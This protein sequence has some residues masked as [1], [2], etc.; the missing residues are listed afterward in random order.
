MNSC[1]QWSCHVYRPGF[2]STPSG[3]LVLIFFPP[4]LVSV[5]WHWCREMNNHMIQLYQFGA[6]TPN[7]IIQGQHCSLHIHVDSLRK[8]IAWM[9]ISCWIENKHGVHV[10]NG[11][12]FNHRDGLNH[13][14]FKVYEWIWKIHTK[15]GHPGLKTQ[16]PL[17][18]LICPYDVQILLMFNT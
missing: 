9:S 15:G 16:M 7:Y 6:Y 1:V 2:H 12:L 13:N 11:I 14:V 18:F 10:Q 3:A 17:G 8:G 4:L 5:Q